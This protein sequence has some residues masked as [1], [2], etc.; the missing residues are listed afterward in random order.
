M[1]ETTMCYV[2]ADPK[3]PGAAWA[4]CVDTPKHRVDTLKNIVQWE[5]QG[6][7]V[8]LVGIE[9]GRAMLMKWVRPAKVKKA[10]AAR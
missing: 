6:A 8:K 3:Q 5:R 4:I 9:E 10:K 1:S 2:A 7:E